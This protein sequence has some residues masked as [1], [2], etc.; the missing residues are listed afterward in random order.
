MIK[1][2]SAVEPISRLIQNTDTQTE[3][4]TGTISLGMI[5]DETAIPQL[6]ELLN[7]DEANIRW[8]SA[9]ALAKM[10]EESSVPIIENLMDREYLMTFPEL[11]Y[12]EINKVIMTAIETSSLVLDNRFEPRLVE[13]ARSD[14]SL[15]VRDAAI[16]TLKKSYDRT[17]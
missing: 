15:T 5:G 4:L 9:I 14:E 1:Y 11:D 10:G 7:D 2:N 17:I 3:R 16:K 13:L 6:K 8:D 12:K